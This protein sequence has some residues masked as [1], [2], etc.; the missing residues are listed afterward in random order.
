MQRITSSIETVSWNP[1]FSIYDNLDP[2]SNEADVSH[3]EPAKYPSAKTSTDERLTI[4]INPVSISPQ[5]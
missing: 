2:D 5:A 4:S 3:A 1:Q